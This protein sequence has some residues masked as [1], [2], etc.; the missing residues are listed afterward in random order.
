MHG[1]KPGQDT[2]NKKAA[3]G[4]NTTTATTRKATLIIADYARIHWVER[5]L[6]PIFSGIFT[7]N[8]LLKIS[9]VLL[10]VLGVAK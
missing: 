2:S 8:N 3:G 9:F 5:H 6:I 4:Y 7:V 10:I 1:A